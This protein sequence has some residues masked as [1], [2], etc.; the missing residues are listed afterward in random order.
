MLTLPGGAL[1]KREGVSVVDFQIIALLVSGL[2]N[3]DIS[4]IL[5]IPL[6]TIQRRARKVVQNKLVEGCIQPN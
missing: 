4:K 6:S 1:Q 2:E 3:R 5:K